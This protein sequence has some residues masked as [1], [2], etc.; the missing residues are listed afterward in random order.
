MILISIITP[1]KDCQTYLEDMLQS[2][3]GQTYL[4]WEL[5]LVDDHSADLSHQIMTT[6]AARDS[7]IKVF[8]NPGRGIVPA[9]QHALENASGSLITRMDADDIMPSDKLT[10][11]SDTLINEPC[12][13]ISTGLVKYFGNT[14]VSKGYLDYE[15]WLNE[16][17]LNAVQWI[18]IYRECVIASPNWM[19]HTNDLK[20]MGGFKT[21]TYPEDYDLTLQWYRSGFTIKVVPKG[22]HLWREHPERTSRTSDLYDQAHFFDLKIK[23]FVDFDWNGQPVIVWGK[24]QK[25]KLTR[26][27]LDSLSVKHQ[28]MGLADFETV[29]DFPRL[30]ILVAVYPEKEQRERLESFLNKIGRKEG[31]D[32]WY[33]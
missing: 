9:L 30:Q 20:A 4:H 8:R 21:L 13:T 27:K 7:R 17:N 14:P 33:L 1:V 11:L 22:T 16:T 15:K 31:R 10:L 19:M 18:K 6:W 5:L 28:V 25:S 29:K 23:A 24:N 26:A 3:I 12:K 2:V 32:W